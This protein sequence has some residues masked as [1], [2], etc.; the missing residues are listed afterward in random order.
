MFKRI[1]S[2]IEN[3]NNGRPLYSILSL[4]SKIFL[5]NDIDTDRIKTLS[6]FRKRIL[7]SWLRVGYRVDFLNLNLKSAYKKRILLKLYI[8]MGIIK[9]D[10]ILADHY[11]SVINNINLFEYIGLD[12]KVK[13]YI[14]LINTFELTKYKCKD[15]NSE[16]D[17]LGRAVL[18]GPNI[19][20]KEFNLNEFDTI[21]FIKPP[22]IEIDLENK[23]LIIF[24]NNAWIKENKKLIIEW[25]T[26][27]PA[28]IFISPQDIKE[29]NIH[30]DR[31][32]SKMPKGLFGASPMGLQRALL[33]LKSKFIYQELSI[34]GFDFSLSEEPY[35][36]SYPSIIETL[37]NQKDIILW[38]N[39]VHDFLYNF[40]L[41]K[42]ILN[43]DSRINGSLDDIIKMNPNDLIELFEDIYSR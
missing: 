27:F 43:N 21:V 16:F 7:S 3:I 35:H 2:F 31:I 10:K 22:K 1:F 5:L 26:K 18:L 8:S 12:Q 29:I 4:V 14:N 6:S 19:D 33:I 40:Y 11:L 34:C 28:S 38:S 25:D 13:D 42:I 17:S 30:K 9:G 41:T 24:L 32:F 15:N 20:I 39:S 36:D 37:G 23:N